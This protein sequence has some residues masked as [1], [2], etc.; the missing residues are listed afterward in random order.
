MENATADL[1]MVAVVLVGMVFEML[2]V[3]LIISALVLMTQ[4]NI[5][6][7]YPFLEPEHDYIGNPECFTVCFLWS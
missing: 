6:V 3:G 2:G 4:Q 5:V 7:D 1:R